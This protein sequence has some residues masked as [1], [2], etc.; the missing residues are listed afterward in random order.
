[1][2]GY[3]D[4]QNLC[5]SI[6][7]GQ[8]SLPIQISGCHIEMMKLKLVAFL[9]LRSQRERVEDLV[10]DVVQAYHNGFNKAIHNYSRILH[11]FSESKEQVLADHIILSSMIILS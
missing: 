4:L 11:L 10:D 2:L 1:L 5:M 7:E 9:Q 8:F 6:P 3:G